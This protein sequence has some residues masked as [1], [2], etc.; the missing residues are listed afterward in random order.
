MWLVDINAAPV[1]VRS[2]SGTVS[3]I[4]E[5]E[6]V[7]IHVGYLIHSDKLVIVVELVDGWEVSVLLFAIVMTIRMRESE[8][9]YGKL[10]LQYISEDTVGQVAHHGRSF[11][12]QL[13]HSLHVVPPFIGSAVFVGAVFSSEVVVGVQI[14]S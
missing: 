12:S 11:L 13:D 14:L 4:L 5:S 3:T 9:K 6:L 7:L 10:I 8:A 1:V 2:L